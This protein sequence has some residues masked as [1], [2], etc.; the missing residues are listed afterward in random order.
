[1]T[2]CPNG[3][4]HPDTYPF[5]NTPFCHRRLQLDDVYEWLQH[6]HPAL[7]ESLSFRASVMEHAAFLE[8][9]TADPDDGFQQQPRRRRNKR[10]QQQQHAQQGWVWGQDVLQDWLSSSPQQDWLREQWMQQ[11]V[12]QWEAD[13]A[14]G[15]TEAPSA[16]SSAGIDPDTADAGYAA[17]I[18]P[19][20][21][22]EA[23][24]NPFAALAPEWQQGEDDSSTFLAELQ[25]QQT[26][27]E[28]DSSTSSSQPSPTSSKFGE[29]LLL[30]GLGS[31]DAA[32][33][34]ANAAQDQDQES[35]DEG[36]EVA[37]MNSSA[38]AEGLQESTSSSDTAS[39]SSAAASASDQTDSSQH[40]HGST[41]LQQ[42]QHHHQQQHANASM[43]SAA[44]PACA[45]PQQSVPPDEVRELEA[46]D[47]PIDELLLLEDIQGMSRSVPH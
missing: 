22:S 37:S 9:A 18:R 5:V 46:L 42:Q 13:A 35:A 11:R 31:T 33:P 43:G 20:S 26:L 21:S 1:M 2:P 29:W 32:P 10:G 36:W 44:A 23:S 4:S 28:G 19:G 17:G 16:G 15:F 12:Q 41:L 40:S 25:G 14:R 6:K 27:G 7:A 3:C 45:E 38:G 39:P 34:G 8:E 30:D 24:S 47:R